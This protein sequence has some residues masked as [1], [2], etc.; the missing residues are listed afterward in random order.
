MGSQ[1]WTSV[2]GGDDVR[3]ASNSI[4]KENFHEVSLKQNPEPVITGAPQKKVTLAAAGSSQDSALVETS[5][6]RPRSAPVHAMGATYAT[7]RGFIAPKRSGEVE[8]QTEAKLL[9]QNI[10]YNQ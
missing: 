10:S 3:G 8:S 7:S 9:Q 5:P 2:L 1:A 6:P 4:G